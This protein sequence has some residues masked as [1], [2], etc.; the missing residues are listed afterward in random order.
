MPLQ[1][2]GNCS[3]LANVGSAQDNRCQLCTPG[4][5]NFVPG[6]GCEGNRGN[7][8]ELGS[9]TSPLPPSLP[10][11]PSFLPPPFPACGCSELSLSSEC[12]AVAGRCQCQEGAIG[13]KCD[14]C[15]FGFTGQPLIKDPL[16]FVLCC[17]L[18]PN[19]NSVA[20]M[21]VGLEAM[22]MGATTLG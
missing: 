4:F 9:I 14:K 7:A 15:A 16:A 19:K 5:F 8:Y 21:S 20:N 3:C 22:F 1:E 12:D 10:P 13:L 18:G 6:I 2:S 11:S 17:D